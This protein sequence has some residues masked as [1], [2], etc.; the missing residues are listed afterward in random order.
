MAAASPPSGQRSRMRSLRNDRRRGD[1]PLTARTANWN[2]P[3]STCTALAAVASAQAHTRAL[4][5]L[6]GTAIHEQAG[7]YPAPGLAGNYSVAGGSRLFRC[8]RKIGR[9]VL[10][11]DAR[12]FGCATVKMAQ[13]NGMSSLD[14]C[15]CAQR[16]TAMRRSIDLS[17]PP[18]ASPRLCVRVQWRPRSRLYR[19][20]RCTLAG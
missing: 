5:G 17:A 13:R 12:A 19:L 1:P 8:L 10:S 2:R 4:V 11:P 16:S 6:D 14:E 20:S 18:R 9:H 15:P 3:F 7:F